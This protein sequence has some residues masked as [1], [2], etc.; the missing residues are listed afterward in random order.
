VTRPGP[1]PLPRPDLVGADSRRLGPVIGVRNL[2]EPGVLQRLLCRDAL[3]RVVDKYLLE[4][5]QK[6]SQELG[7]WWNDI[8][9]GLAADGYNER[10]NT[11]R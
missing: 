7:G 6:L 8:L 10:S 4:K 11:Y 2:A 5:I 9:D 3:R 1:L